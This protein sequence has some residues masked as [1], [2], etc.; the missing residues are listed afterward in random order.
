MEAINIFNVIYIP[1]LRLGVDCLLHQHT[2]AHDGGG[3]RRERERKTKRDVWGG[4]GADK[5]VYHWE[6]MPSDVFI[7]YLTLIK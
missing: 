5:T 1:P 7:C 4:V 3:V 6:P 2:L